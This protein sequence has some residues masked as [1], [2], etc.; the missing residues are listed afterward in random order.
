MTNATDRLK[1]QLDTMDPQKKKRLERLARVLHGGDIA[2]FE[3]ILELE[4]KAEIAI[5]NLEKKIQAAIESLD[6][7]EPE[8]DKALNSIQVQLDE[9]TDD[10]SLAARILS[11]IPSAVPGKDYV[12]TPEDKKQIADSIEIPV[13]E[14]VIER[15]EVIREQPIEIVKEKAVPD[16]PAETR[17]KLE[18]LEGDDRLDKKAVKGLDVFIDQARLDRAVSILDSRTNY[19]INRVDALGRSGSRSSISGLSGQV[20]YFDGNNN[21]AGDPDLA[22]DKATNALT[23]TNGSQV[24]AKSSL[25]FT[26]ETAPGIPTIALVTTST[27]NCTNG[28]HRVKVTFVT[29]AGETEASAQS[30]SVTV[31]NTHKQISLTGI[32]TGTAGVVTGRNI[33]MSKAS[34]S[35]FFRLGAGTTIA[36]NTTTTLTINIAD[37]SLNA[38]TAPT[39]NTTSGAIFAAGTKRIILDSATGNVDINTPLFEVLRSNGAPEIQVDTVNHLLYAFQYTTDQTGA[40]SAEHTGRGSNA[41]VGGT[42]GGANANAG[43]RGTAYG[44]NNISGQDGT[45]YGAGTQATIFG[46]AFGRGSYAGDT[47]GAFGLNVF[48]NAPGNTM[49]MSYVDL[50]LGN[51]QVTSPIDVAYHGADIF[52]GNPNIAGGN[53][54]L[55][56][57]VSTGNKDG[58]DFL[59]KQSPH[60]VSGSSA[61]AVVEHIRTYAGTG[62]SVFT[63]EVNTVGAPTNAAGTISYSSAG[64]FTT[65]YATDGTTS[66]DFHLYAFKPSGGGIWSP[67]ENV[68]GAPFVDNNGMLN[69]TNSIPTGGSAGYTPDAGTYLADGTQ[70]DY[71]VYSVSTFNGSVCFCPTDTTASISPLENV[72]P[73]AIFGGSVTQ[74]IGGGTYGP[75]TDSYAYQ[76]YGYCQYNGV[77]IFSAT[78]SF[79]GITGDGSSSSVAYDVSWT[80]I[81]FPSGSINQQYR[82][83][84][85]KNFAGYN[86]YVDTGS[87]AASYADT[88]DGNWTPGNTVS[89]TSTPRLID[90]NLTWAG[91]TFPSYSTANFYRILRQVAGGGFNEYIDVADPTISLDD[92]GNGLWSAGSTVT[93]T[94]VPDF[95]QIPFTW[96]ASPGATAYK[97][98]RTIA[99]VD[100]ATLLGNVTAFTDT[101]MLPWADSTTVTPTSAPGYITSL[102]TA[103]TGINTVNTDGDA[104]VPVFANNAAAIAAGLVVGDFY[105]GGGDPDPLYIVH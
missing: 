75:D 87:T 98:I 32:P 88:A 56:P 42:A 20:L 2:L 85:N 4:D 76:I 15:T 8:I 34:G 29:A 21:P 103:T 61:N 36:D 95:Y 89:P 23:L 7:I 101:G 67:V 3:F 91:T 105:R 54:T 5:P 19:L 30:A 81:T 37:G 99:S 39:N 63:G 77:D 51:Y 80:A 82:I 100:D 9:K 72:T 59:L 97:M 70:R 13:A 52:P 33:Y 66:R 53:L 10:E 26:Y 71:Q 27:G 35:G 48:N 45:S 12:L 6:A 40:S 25:N 102:N 16:T 69:I 18:S 60:G 92:T 96:T 74:D 73:D 14:K 47:N 62:E 22:W 46:A 78:P 90:V 41:A 57:G 1:D 86:E 31:D 104:G 49:A 84:R 55:Q 11:L 50:Y 93:P 38:A 94:M 65:G 64:G 68:S 43:V 24:L 79:T 28:G 83:L 17:D 44:A 58:G